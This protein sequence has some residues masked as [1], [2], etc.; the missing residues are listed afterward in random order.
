MAVVKL[1][2]CKTAAPAGQS[3][4]PATGVEAAAT[5]VVAVAGKPF[6]PEGL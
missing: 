1:E 5:Q 2:V 3:P 4:L 6:A